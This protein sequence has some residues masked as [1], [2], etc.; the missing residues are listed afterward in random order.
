MSRLVKTF[1]NSFLRRPAAPLVSNHSSIELYN[2]STNFVRNCND[3]R[4]AK[5]NCLAQNGTQHSHPLGKLEGKL[6]LSYTCKV[7]DTRNSNYISKVAYHSGVVLVKCTGCSNHHIIADN[8]KWFSDLKGKRNIEEILAEKGE[9]VTKVDL[10]GCIEA[11]A[12]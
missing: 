1:L 12:K 9:S 8:L 11:L 5:T 3:H 4:T 7:C 2:K 6:Y 10:G